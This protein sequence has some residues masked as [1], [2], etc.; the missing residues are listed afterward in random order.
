MYQVNFSEE[1]GEGVE[2]Y[3]WSVTLNVDFTEL[4]AWNADKTDYGDLIAK[5]YNQ[6]KGSQTSN[7][8]LILD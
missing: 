6:V 3:K 8:S 1:V 5:E 2:I 4:T 7:F